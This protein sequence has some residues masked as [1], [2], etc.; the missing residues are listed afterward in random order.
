MGGVHFI[1]LPSGEVKPYLWRSP[2]SRE[3]RTRLITFSNP[4]GTIT[5]S[6]LELA[7]SVAQHDILAHQADVREATIHNSYDN[8][9]TVWW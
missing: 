4:A 6:D 8:I 1:P 9:D 5:N 2:F 3:V 7:V